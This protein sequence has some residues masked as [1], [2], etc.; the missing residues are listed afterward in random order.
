ME[1]ELTERESGEHKSTEPEST[2]RESKELE[3]TEPESPEPMLREVFH[4]WE[5]PEQLK[6]LSEIG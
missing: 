1:P 4:V 5:V 3:L 2:E 6:V